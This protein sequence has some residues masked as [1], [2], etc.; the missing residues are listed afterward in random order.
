MLSSSLTM[1]VSTTALAG[2]RIAPCSKI[3]PLGR[4]S[5][6]KMAVETSEKL[7]EDGLGAASESGYTYSPGRDED[8]EL[9]RKMLVELGGYDVE[10]GIGPWDPLG[11]ATVTGDAMDVGARCMLQL[12]PSG[13]VHRSS[14][15]YPAFT[16]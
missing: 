6:L 9:A 2:P 8:R 1:L 12:D 11:L 15:A 5:S 7:V 4:T 13:T 14:D 3:S 10:S 16:P